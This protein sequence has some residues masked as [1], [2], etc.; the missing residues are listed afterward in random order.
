M[1]DERTPLRFK[2]SSWKQ[3]T[4]CKSNN[5]RNLS[6]KVTN[7]VNNGYL[8]GLRIQVVH[9]HFGVLF[10]ETL[11]ARGTCTTSLDG[12]DTSV[13]TFQLDTAHILSEL[14]KFGFYVTFNPRKHLPESMLEYL[15]TLRN[16]L[17]DKLRVLN[18]EERQTDGTNAYKWYVVGFKSCT[19][20][21]WLNN[22]YCASKQEF[23]EALLDGSAINI[24]E[25]ASAKGFNWSWLDYVANITDILK[26]NMEALVNNE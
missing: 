16:L 10:A 1:W 14:R 13:I 3:L 18:V 2:I 5:D 17:F 4:G 12:S 6:I 15:D 7:F 20:K 25:L 26:D 19:H 8:T 11:N 23:V 24:S 22:T 21:D 9:P